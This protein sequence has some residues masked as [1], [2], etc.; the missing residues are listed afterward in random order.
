MTFALT[1]SV[2]TYFAQVGRES[3]GSQT[4]LKYMDRYGFNSDPAARLPVGPDDSR[5]VSTGPTDFLPQSAP[6][7]IGRVAIGQANLT[8]HAS[9]DGRG[10]GH[11][12]QQGVLE[13]PTF[14]QQVSDPDGRTISSL[15]PQA[16]STVMSPKTASE[17]TSMMTQGDAGGT[18]AGLTVQGLPF[19]RQDRHR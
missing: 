9:S 4:M 11:G 19:R 16:Q 6:V 14:V 18:A 17:L 2:N 15:S 8:G 10:G 1:H 7:D 5:A 3:L 13:K 12:R